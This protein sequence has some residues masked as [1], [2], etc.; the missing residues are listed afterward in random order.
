MNRRTLLASATNTVSLALAG[1]L[2]STDDTSTP[3]GT[4]TATTQSG[5]IVEDIIVRKAVTYESSMGSGG[6]LAE[7]G[8]QYVVASV[9]SDRDLSPSAFTFVADRESWDPGLP[10]TAG[11]ANF[12][13]AG[14]EGGAVGSP[15]G[16]EGSY[17]TFAV[18]SPLSG[19]G[20][21]IRYDGPGG[22]EWLLPEAARDRLPAPEPEFERTE[23]SVPETVEQG[24]PMTVSMT[25]ENVAETE[26]RFLV[27]VYWPT[28][29]IA[30]DDESHIVDRTVR[31]GEEINPSVQIDTAYTTDENGEIT[32][33][34]R[35]HVRA[36]RTVSVTDAS[37]PS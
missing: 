30:D 8:R 29:L 37:R 23:L 20:A 25:V 26:G 27:A 18:P 15:L 3:A 31:S 6:V 28:A 2:D 4:D 1:C 34:V 14:R 10:D 32:L 17:L 12:A 33:R 19:S 5:V 11:A 22:G 24:Q 35:G 13:V 9:R 16:I 36:E 7:R 21:R